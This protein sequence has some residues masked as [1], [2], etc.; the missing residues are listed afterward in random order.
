MRIY[1]TV[2]RNNGKMY[3]GRDSRRCDGY[4][5]SGVLLLQAIEK[6][7][8]ESFTKIILEDLGPDAELRVAIDCEKKWIEIFQAPDNPMFYNLSWDCGGMGKGDRHSEETK[9]HISNVMKNE[10][11]KNGLPPVWKENVTRALKGRIPW[12]KGKKTGTTQ[13]RPRR[14]FTDEEFES[15]KAEYESGV[16]AAKLALKWNVSHHTILAM[17]K[18]NSAHPKRKVCHP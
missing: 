5:G 1:L 11:Y 8:R 4:L 16:S 12:N 14:V 18:R 3:V 9:K 17:I 2:N 6:H 10:V 15:I 13:K 7:G